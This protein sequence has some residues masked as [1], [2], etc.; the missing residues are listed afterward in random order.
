[1]TSSIVDC[2][3]TVL[4]Y[5]F[6]GLPSGAYVAILDHDARVLVRVDSALGRDHVALVRVGQAG[7]DGAVLENCSPVAEYEVDCADDEATGEELA[8]GV[9]VQRVLISEHVASVECR[10]IGPHAQGHGLVLG[11]AR[12]VLEGDVPREEPCSD[13]GCRII[14][15][16]SVNN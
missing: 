7:E 5:S 14:K 9:D 11:R 10:E 13:R 15:L 1:M 12:R 8:V 2:M 4:L 6:H 3:I 16:D